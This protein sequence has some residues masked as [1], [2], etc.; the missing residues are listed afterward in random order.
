MTD[1]H[2]ATQVVPP[3]P[4]W[5]QRAAIMPGHWLLARLGKRVLRPGGTAMTTQLLADAS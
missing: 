2:R 1:T 4:R 3:L 5:Q